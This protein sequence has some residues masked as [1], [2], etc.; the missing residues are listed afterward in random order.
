MFRACGPETSEHR[1]ALD[2]AETDRG[3]TVELGP[4]RGDGEVQDDAG[5]ISGRAAVGWRSEVGYGGLVYPN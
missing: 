5:P 2:M 4:I 1:R 3:K